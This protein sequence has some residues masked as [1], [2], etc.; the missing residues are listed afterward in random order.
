MEANLRDAKVGG[1]DVQ[2]RVTGVPLS[3]A[4]VPGYPTTAQVEMD[5]II[6][7][8]RPV[9]ESVHGVPARGFVI[10]KVTVEPGEVSV[11]G[12]TSAVRDVARAVAVVDVS[13]I[14]KSAPF[15]VRAEARDNRNVAVTGVELRPAIVTVTVEVRELN[16]KYVPVRPVLG[17]PPSGYRVSGVR[18]DPEIVTIT[19]DQDLTQLQSVPTLLVDISGLRGT[20]D[21]SVSLN[22]PSG[23]RVEGP[24]A[25]Q[26][27]VTTQPVGATPFSEPP[28]EG[29]SPTGGA[30]EEVGGEE[31]NPASPVNQT[32]EPGSGEISE[33]GGP[34]SAAGGAERDRSDDGHATRVTTPPRGDG[35]GT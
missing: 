20:K 15:E 32:D 6:T 29:G 2:L 14:N 13:G 30:Q 28:S 19:S 33:Q 8:A 23:M 18:A 3:L 31:E 12:A 22:V 35:G 7:R 1:N 24:A 34:Q 26:V 10:E 4:V 17:N 5:T 16:V 9:N 27:T 21:Y 25:V 11:R